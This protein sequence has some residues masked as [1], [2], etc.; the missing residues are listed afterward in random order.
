MGI[1]ECQLEK[2]Q[3]E[4]EVTQK[5]YH[6]LEQMEWRAALQVKRGDPQRVK[7]CEGCGMGRSASLVTGGLQVEL[8]TK[9]RM[10][11]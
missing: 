1:A 5:W 11:S 7:T 3:L 2:P 4:L 10:E 9:R 6:H 8:Y